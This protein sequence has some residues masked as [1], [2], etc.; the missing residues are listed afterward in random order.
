MRM[1]DIISLS[2]ILVVFSSMVSSTLSSI[3]MLNRKLEAIKR[4]TD[5]LI[6]ISESFKSCC[7]G[8]GFSSFDEWKQVCGSL[9]KLENIEW[10]NMHLEESELYCG[11]W[12]GPEG[13]GEVYVKRECENE[14][15]F[16]HH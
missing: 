13:T 3:E 1:I 10:E 15:S 4:K 2:V 12:D 11:K 6:F 8:K 5:S 14:S 7:Q 9:W 16:K